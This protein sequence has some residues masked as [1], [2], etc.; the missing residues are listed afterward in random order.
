[1]TGV[2]T[3]TKRSGRSPSRITP[4]VNATTGCSPAIG[5]ALA[6][7]TIDIAVMMNNRAMG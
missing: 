1:M 5:T 3:M 7:P 6:A 4:N 2:P